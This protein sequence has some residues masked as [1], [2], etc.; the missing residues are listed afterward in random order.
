LPTNLA[1]SA[2]YGMTVLGSSQN[3]S[4]HD[5]SYRFAMYLT[6]PQA[7]AIVPLYGFGAVATASPQ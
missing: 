6:S 5:A 4:T 7:Q 3:K 2:D 1:I